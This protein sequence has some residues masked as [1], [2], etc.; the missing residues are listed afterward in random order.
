MSNQIQAFSKLPFAI[1]D[2]V[3]RPGYDILSATIEDKNNTTQHI[4]FD[5]PKEDL[6][7][8]FNGF[9]YLQQMPLG[10]QLTSATLMDDGQASVPSSRNF[11]PLME[12]PT[13]DLGD[14]NIFSTVGS[15]SKAEM[16]SLFSELNK[17]YSVEDYSSRL[18]QIKSL[19]FQT[20][21]SDYK[22]ALIAAQYLHL[23]TECLPDLISIIASNP[24]KVMDEYNNLAATMPSFALS[25]FSIPILGCKHLDVIDINDYFYGVE[26][27]LFR[28]GQTV[29][30]HRDCLQ[31]YAL[32]FMT[33]EGRIKDYLNDH[34]LHAP[35]ISYMR[36]REWY[37]KTQTYKL[38]ATYIDKY[39]V[40]LLLKSKVGK[41]YGIPIAMGV[42]LF[43]YLPDS[44]D[45]KLEEI[46]DYA[47]YILAPAM[48]FGS[49]LRSDVLR[50]ELMKKL[51]LSSLFDSAV[52]KDAGDPDTDSYYGLGDIGLKY[53]LNT[54]PE[55]G[56]FF[57]NLVSGVGKFIGKTGIGKA[58]I[59]AGS[60]ALPKLMPFL[61]A[62]NPIVGL[63]AS[64][65]P[66]LISSLTS[67]SKTARN[68]SNN[69][70]DST[71]ST[72]TGIDPV[73]AEEVLN[74]LPKH[75][76]DQLISALSK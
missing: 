21:G 33:S 45:D 13:G 51:V 61:S 12:P 75:I 70:S 22:D 69:P 66:K 23:I 53:Y 60:F 5:S 9:D 64:F 62:L 37:E 39:L 36:A 11:I 7:S 18:D 32:A 48:V 67:R 34:V 35:T 25:P 4:V 26:A 8:G 19:P 1:N 65:L 46:D 58:L 42:K 16:N 44:P 56:G 59:K 50:L 57:S 14:Q 43:D 2:R 27:M 52:I 63:G 54:V 49:A 68:N 10:N 38:V 28:I 76:Q 24:S 31:P 6:P 3:N 71:E 29:A 41:K 17:L 30:S 40:P 47:Y 74:K 55:A 73:K 20:T 72:T 15:T